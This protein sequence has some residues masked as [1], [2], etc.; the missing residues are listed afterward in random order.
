MPDEQSSP[1]AM[2]AAGEID[3]ELT[4]CALAN[5]HM[6]F[7]QWISPTVQKLA[8]IIDREMQPEWIKCSERMPQEGVEV[9]LG[10][11]P[12]RIVKRGVLKDGI[13]YLPD[14][15]KYSQ[16]IFTCWQPI[17]VPNDPEPEDAT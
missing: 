3:K 9:W 14:G 1:E 15:R 11:A 10:G 7:V 8:T 2:R 17:I 6:P 12:Y 4:E 5:K 13:W 16:Q